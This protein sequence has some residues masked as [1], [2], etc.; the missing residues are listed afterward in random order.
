VWND[1]L[2]AKSF[3]A[4][5]I[6]L[7]M[8]VFMSLLPAG[9]YQAYQSITKGLWYARS[10]EVIH[11]KVMETLVWLRVPGDIV[12]AAGSVF[13]ALYA[14]YLLRRPAVQQVPAGAAVEI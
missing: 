13:L 2:I 8:M 7:A 12:F 1:S 3:W 14:L 9:I 5:N 10:P 6:G 11:S 4:L